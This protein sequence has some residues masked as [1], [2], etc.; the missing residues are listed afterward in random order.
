VLQ[1]VNTH[2]HHINVVKGM[3]RPLRNMDRVV[4]GGVDVLDTETLFTLNGVL[5]TA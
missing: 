3:S 2:A 4:T 5:A 1:T